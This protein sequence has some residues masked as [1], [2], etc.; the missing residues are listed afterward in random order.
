MFWNEEMDSPRG[1]IYMMQSAADGRIPLD[2][3]FQRHMDNCLGCMACM[4][5]CPSGVEYNKLIEDTRG[6]VE[7]NVR[8]GVGDWLFRRMLF[9]TFPHPKRL[10]AVAP[11]LRMYQRKGLQRLVRR[12]GMLKLLPKR[13]AAMEA[14]LPEVPSKRGPVAALTA[15]A[16]MKR[17][18]VGML[19]GCVQSVFF[20]RV[21]EATARVLAAE[22]CE[23][24]TPEEQP[25]CGALM[26][27]SGLGAAGRGDGAEDHPD[28]RA[29]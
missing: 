22:G 23:V 10:R 21:N 16:G 27:H 5:A 9:A 24:I 7:R 1:R 12:S 2:K 14:L 26:L 6:Q 11:L 18:R 15:A 13:M 3:T 29:R 4:T 25:C 8:R 20:S 17:R 28:I 19:T